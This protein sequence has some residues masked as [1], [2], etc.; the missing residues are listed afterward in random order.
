MKN[1]NLKSH[2]HSFNINSDKDFSTLKRASVVLVFAIEN[3]QCFVLFMKRVQ[4]RDD[5]WSGHYAFPGGMV[6]LNEGFLEAAKRECFEEVGVSLDD[7]DLIGRCDDYYISQSKN[8]VIRPF[9]FL[10]KKKTALINC[11]KEVEE[12]FWW[13]LTDLIKRSNCEER[14]FHT[15]IGEMKRPCIIYQEH[16]IWG[17]TLSIFNNLLTLWEGQEFFDNLIVPYDF[18]S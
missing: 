6:D 15:M 3:N 2:L 4:N 11:E 10:A 16:V 9:V 13:P 8:F 5:P 18:Q 7:A 1:S 14:T 17:I 12:S